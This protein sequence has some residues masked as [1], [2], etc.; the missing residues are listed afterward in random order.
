MG[1]SEIF[2]KK[3]AIKT[4]ADVEQS[5]AFCMKPWVHLFVSTQGTVTPCCLT[6]WE[7]E[8]A[9]GD[10]NVQSLDEIW[11]GKEM[12][13]FRAKMLRDEPDPR[14]WDCYENEKSGLRSSRKL[15]NF[16]Y[17]DKLEWVWETDSKGNAP[18]AKPISWDIRVSNF[19]N[20]KC[21]ICGH[22][23]SSQWFDD[24]N[25]LDQAVYTDKVHYS[26]KDFDALM[27]QLDPVIEELEEIYF[28]GGE[29]LI[30]PEHY[31]LLEVLIER[32]RTDVKLRYNTNFSISI[33]K[34]KNVLDYWKDFEDVFVHA[35]LDATGQQGEYQR[36]GQD[37][38][39]VLEH[40]QLMQEQC[41]HV[42]FLITPTISVFNVLTL[43]DFHKEWVEAGL[44]RID[45][46]MAHTLKSPKEYN[47][48]ILPKELKEQAARKIESH[49]EWI[50]SWVKHSPP[51]PPDESLLRKKGLP[52][53]WI[54]APE[55]TGHLKL[56]MCINE[57]RNCITFMNSADETHLLA[58]FRK[59][60]AKLD[61]LR[62][63]DTKALFPELENLFEN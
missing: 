16:L 17:S 35:S 13:A 49:I 45:E 9:L 8:K 31:Q 4:P 47:L 39:K 5:K 26:V 30:M 42:D 11:N 54:K 12:N 57:F 55:V 1:L 58:R 7:K 3:Q 43:P 34:G 53:H 48:R 6:P 56:D 51:P 15:T 38:S 63:E 50:K 41:P 25:A 14:C 19:C 33:Y 22:H 23:S 28:A 60:T 2:R 24:A 20:F 44:V 52:V 61:E 36:K 18:K 10:L 40:R 29:P 32:G 37:W 62:G 46:M 27:Q 21:R 59:V